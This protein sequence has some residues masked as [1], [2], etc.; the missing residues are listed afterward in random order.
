MSTVGD[1]SEIS[2]SSEPR[3]DSGTLNAS[4]CAMQ[5]RLDWSLFTKSELKRGCK[6]LVLKNYSSL[7]KADLVKKL[8]LATQ[9]QE[10]SAL[11]LYDDLSKARRDR[12]GGS[13][14]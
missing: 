13:K 2:T 1:G 8:D 14:P 5:K 6:V 7:V 3:I 12:Q 10:T 4:D 11:E 9:E